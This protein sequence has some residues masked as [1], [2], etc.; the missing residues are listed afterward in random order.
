M[1]EGGL[2][3]WKL[4]RNP[5][6]GFY[7]DYSKLSA[8]LPTPPSGYHWVRDGDNAPALMDEHT[9]VLVSHVPADALE[10]PP[11][12]G[13]ASRLPPAVP[14]AVA[15]VVDAVVEMPE[16]LE[17]VVGERN[18]QIAAAPT[19]RACQTRLAC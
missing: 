2:N 16:Y 19:V 18:E 8:P 7:V 14:E 10:A 1:S 5:R 9:G 12:G 17:H 6:P 15:V 11:M 3:P 4:Q 13:K